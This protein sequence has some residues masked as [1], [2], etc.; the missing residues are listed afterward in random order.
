[1]SRLREGGKGRTERK[2]GSEGRK[3]KVEDT[4]GRMRVEGW[5]E[6]GRNREEQRK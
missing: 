4:E 1:M 6:R 2:G 3:R 5:K